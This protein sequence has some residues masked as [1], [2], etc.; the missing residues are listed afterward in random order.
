[1]NG[2][3]NLQP[4]WNALINL[5][6]E[7][8]KICVKHGIQHWAVGGTALGAMRHKGFIPWDDDF[9]IAMMRPDYERFWRAAVKELPSNV[10]WMSKDINADYHNSFGKVYD[11]TQGLV[12][13]LKRETHLDVSEGVSIDIYPIDGQPRTRTGLWW[14]KAIRGVLRRL[15][16]FLPVS[17]QNRWR[18][19][20]RYL[21]HIDLKKTPM[22]GNADCD[23]HR[24][25][26][27]F[28]KKSWFETTKMVPFENIEV[29]IPG[30]CE[31]FIAQH[32]RNWR[33]LPP[34][35]NRVP[36]HQNLG[37]GI[38]DF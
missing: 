14:F 36:S 21:Q 1:M 22:C 13:K 3:Y 11:V 19:Y 33:Q 31:E 34:E 16:R 25:F 23:S 28:W 12:E 4:L 9:D 6:G 17:P 29:P 30:K 18:I 15:L 5:Y 35:E 38:I 10:I 7:I 24:Q 2:E 27:C 26:R 8:N 20:S 32:Y 37:Y